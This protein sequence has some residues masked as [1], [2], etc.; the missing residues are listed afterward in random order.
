MMSP[1]IIIFLLFIFISSFIIISTSEENGN[2]NGKNKNNKKTKKENK[3]NED[4][5]FIGNPYLFLQVPPWSKFNDVQKRF[6][7][8]K[9]K[10]I[11]QKKTHTRNYNLM[12]KSYE[13][14]EEEY[15]NSG[16][17]DK[18]FFGVLINTFKNIFIYELLMLIVLF[19]TWFIYKFNTYAAL[20]VVAFV[21]I[22]NLIPHWFGYMIT[23][24]IVSF[25][26]GTIIYFR[27]FFLSFI[28]GDKKTDN[29]N[30]DNTN[31]GHVERRRFVKI[32]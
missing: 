24:Y 26:L 4:D 28:Y 21:T 23:Q 32:E 25:L 20:L 13:K 31:S 2:E 7:Y 8:L 29:N 17:K 5:I 15:I 14:I 6:N 11:Y 9:D 10:A 12:K 30:N 1:K 27:G 18:T 3:N 19:I 22:D 16:Y